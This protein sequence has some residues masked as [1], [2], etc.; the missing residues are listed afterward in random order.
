MCIFRIFLFREPCRLPFRAAGRQKCWWNFTKIMKKSWKIEKFWIFYLVIIHQYMIILCNKGEYLQFSNDHYNRAYPPGGGG[1][2]I[3][4]PPRVV[5]CARRRSSVLCAKEPT[6]PASVVG[7]LRK[8]TH[9]AGARCPAP[10]TQSQEVALKF[11]DPLFSRAKR[12]KKKVTGGASADT[13]PKAPWKAPKAPWKAPK[14]PWKVPKT[15][16]K[17]PKVPVHFTR[18]PWSYSWWHYC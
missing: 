12:V 15:L 11:F 17:A 13:A 7:T 9:I 3:V 1:A 18:L 6:P 14:A 16:W 5:F 10:Y 2:K 8:K 4:P